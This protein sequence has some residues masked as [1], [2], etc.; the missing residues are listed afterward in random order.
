VDKF[1][2]LETISQVS[3]TFAGFAAVIVGFAS[4]S[5]W[6]D[7]EAIGL[8]HFLQISLGV[9]LLALVP[10]ALSTNEATADY[11]WRASNAVLGLYHLF[12][13]LWIFR[14]TKFRYAHFAMIGGLLI[15]GLAVIG[16][17]SSI[18]SLAV[19]AGAFKSYEVLV[20]FFGLLWLLGMSLVSFVA[21]VLG[22]IRDPEAM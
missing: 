12:L 9:V 5:T 19:A 21:I 16:I 4:S 8:I 6:G 20:F 2:F 11:A 3:A 7:R 18:L 1:S 13:I 14:K 10:G 15:S 22:F 17:S